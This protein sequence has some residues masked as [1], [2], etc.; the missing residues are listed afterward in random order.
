MS[1]SLLLTLGEIVITVILCVCV[2]VC[3]QKLICR[4]VLGQ[5]ALVKQAGR[6]LQKQ[7]GIYSYKCLV[8]KLEHPLLTLIN[9]CHLVHTNIHIIIL[10]YT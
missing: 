7:K 3:P 5:K 10:Y 2:S 8:K 1:E 4:L 9:V 6:I